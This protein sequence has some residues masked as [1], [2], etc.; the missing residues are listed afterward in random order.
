M[1]QEIRQKILE[2]GKQYY[3]QSNPVKSFEPGVTF[4]PANGKVVDSDDLS[5]LLDASLDMWLTAGRYAEKFENEFAEIFGTRYC[6]LVNS[7]SSANLVA[8]SALTS[9]LLKDRALKPGDEFITP[10]SGFPTTVNPGL[11]FGMVPRFIDVDPKIH[12]VTPELVEA[13]I[14]AKTKLVMIAHTLGNPY[15]SEKIA[16]ICKDRGIWF[17]EDCCDALGA[18]VNGKNVGTFGDVATCSFYPA[19]HITMGEGG[20]VLMNS[21]IIKKLAE[22]F[23]DWGR[24]CY[25]PPAKEDSCGKRYCWKLGDLPKG[26]D[27]KYIYSHIGYNLKVT[28]MQ[29]ALGVSQL[30]KLPGFIKARVE[31]FEFLSSEMERIGASKY[32]DIPS[33]I[34]GSEPSWFGFLVTLR[35][36]ALDRAKILQKLNDKKIGT[37]LLFGGNLLKQPAYQNIQHTV[38]GSLQ[39]TNNIMNLSFFVGIWP[40]LNKEMLTYIAQ[41]MYEIA[42]DVEKG[43]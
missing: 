40:G 4:L 15:D 5:H 38:C 8:F 7:G 22:S 19:H 14:T 23:R 35:S 24:D 10:A 11:Q 6:L 37:R 21:P 33:Q 41:N 43:A 17:V 9:P 39:H 26:Y 1:T 42:Q 34:D 25:C 32:Y 30:K 2:L 31:N 29:A 18:K 28:D 13:A 3:N 27:H 20:A 12:N 16:K 36:Q